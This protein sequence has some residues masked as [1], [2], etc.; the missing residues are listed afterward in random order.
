[1]HT[2]PRLHLNLA[3]DPFR[4]DRHLIVLSAAAAVLLAG[5]LAFLILLILQQRDAA[6]ASREAHARLDEEA[7]SL[8]RQESAIAARLRE[9]AN[10]SVLDQSVFLNTL[11]QRK[12]VSWTRLFADLQ[13]VFPH[14]VRLVSV[15]PFTTADNRVQLEM[16]VGAEA[17]APVVD[18]LRRLEG[19]ALFGFTAVQA[20]Q[21]P[22]QNEPLFRYR[23]SVSYAQKL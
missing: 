9:P 13:D 16:I 8:A 18:L 19:S 14:N 1:M 22:T 7:R 20:E 23:V 2:A 11:I 12:A 17:P 6:R 21:P 15:R 3:S 10:A 4:K 5:L